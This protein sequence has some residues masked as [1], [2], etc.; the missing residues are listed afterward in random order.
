MEKKS[1]VIL[2]DNNFW[3]GTLHDVTVEELENELAL[4]RSEME[5]E[6]LNLP[7]ELFVYQISKNYR[8]LKVK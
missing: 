3:Y 1:Y 2:G 5:D 4:L 8:H 6:D 7:D